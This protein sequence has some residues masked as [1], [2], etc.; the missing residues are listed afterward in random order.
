[1]ICPNCGFNQKRSLGTTCTSCRYRFAL[2][3]KVKPWLSDRA[4]QTLL[5]RA[6]AGNTRYFTTAQL[7]AVFLQRQWRKWR[8]AR[9]VGWICLGIFGAAALGV[10]AFNLFLALALALVGILI[11]FASSNKKIC[12]FDSFKELVKKWQKAGKTIER[13]ITRPMLKDPPENQTIEDLYDYGIQRLVIVERPEMVDV[14]VL[15]GWHAE[16]QALVVS[17]GGYPGYIMPLVE[18]YLAE[19]PHLP[20][21][22]LSQSEGMPQRLKSNDRFPLKGHPVEDL[23]FWRRMEPQ[24]RDLQRFQNREGQGLSP[25]FLNYGLLTA[26]LTMAVTSGIDEQMFLP[27]RLEQFRVAFGSSFG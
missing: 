15:N 23:A 13:L 18:R 14:L 5:D 12:G 21:F 7:Y 17:E 2:D 19:Q 8:K 24:T 10:I 16:Q 22:L 6:S 11:F 26:G 1:M 27:E 25:A 9:R 20:V 4:F 3:P